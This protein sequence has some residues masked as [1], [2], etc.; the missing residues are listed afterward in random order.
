MEVNG[1]GFANDLLQAQ[2]SCTAS[3]S[4]QH[5]NKRSEAIVQI[6]LIYCEFNSLQGIKATTKK[7]SPHAS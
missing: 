2:Y 4:S 6:E 1:K 5:T 3:H 7:G